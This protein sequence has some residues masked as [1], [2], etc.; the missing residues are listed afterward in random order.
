MGGQL[1]RGIRA[2]KGSDR[3]GRKFRQIQAS[4]DGQQIIFNFSFYMHIFPSSAAVISASI[5]QTSPKSIQPN[6]TSLSSKGALHR[7]PVPPQPRLDCRVQRH[8]HQTLAHHPK[9][10]SSDPVCVFGVCL[11]VCK[12]VYGGIG[13]VP[14]TCDRSIE[15]T[16]QSIPRQKRNAPCVLGQDLRRA[17][18]PPHGRQLQGRHAIYI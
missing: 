4:W 15:P 5:I 17:P 7:P 18:P 13:G 6:H 14:S 10:L 9:V 1:R 16:N 2:L 8:L 3:K 12:V 11:C